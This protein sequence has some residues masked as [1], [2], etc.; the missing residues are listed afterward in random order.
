MNTTT[1][2]RLDEAGR[3]VLLVGDIVGALSLTFD[4]LYAEMTVAQLVRLA[5]W[6]A[7]VKKVLSLVERDATKAVAD[8]VPRDNRVVEWTDNQGTFRTEVRFKS[9]RTKV[10]KEGLYSAVKKNGRVVDEATGEMTLDNELVVKLIERAFRFEPR[11][12]E[13]K[14]LGIDPDEYCQTR[15][16]PQ[17]ETVQV[18]AENNNQHTQT[19]DNQ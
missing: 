2:E 5:E 7:G 16:E 17:V 11:W 4:D 6:C 12:T 9:V 19:G 13:I 10:D 1:Q 14:E 15:Y 3:Q 18:D 8:M